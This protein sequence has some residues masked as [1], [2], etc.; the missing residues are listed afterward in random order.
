MNYQILLCGVGGQGILLAAK[1][2]G[3]AAEASGL[4]VVANETHGMAQRGGSVKAQ[5]KI[6][7]APGSPL[8]MEGTADVLAALENVEALRNAHYLNPGGLAV[9]SRHSIVPVT[10]TLG[11]AQYPADVEDR[12]RRVFPR[13]IYF[14]CEAKAI[15]LG[16]PKLENTILTG[17][18]SRALPLEV[19]AWHEAIRR[20]V[21]PQF[22]EANIAAFDF[23]RSLEDG[24]K[25]GNQP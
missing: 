6:G 22:A 21:R 8:V 5:V 1:V 12:L 16:N 24:V 18:L 11:Q 25:T 20:S 23:G 9:V 17:M 2:I 13:L 7:E 15:E 4:S 3:A 19:G 10:A 14:D